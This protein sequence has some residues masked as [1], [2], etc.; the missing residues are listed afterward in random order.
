MYE[1][2]I[3]LNKMRINY[4]F[5]YANKNICKDNNRQPHMAVHMLYVTNYKS[6]FK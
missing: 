6:N 3:H 4:E 5:S 1:Y 2:T